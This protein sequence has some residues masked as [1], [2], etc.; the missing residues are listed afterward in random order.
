MMFC[1]DEGSGLTY[2]NGYINKSKETL[3]GGRSQTLP[4]ICYMHRM[5]S[6]TGISQNLVTS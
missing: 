3:L 2:C 4:Y 1:L 6:N 5:T